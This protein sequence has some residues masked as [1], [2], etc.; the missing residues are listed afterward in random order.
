MPFKGLFKVFKRL[1]GVGT[2]RTPIKLKDLGKV[3]KSMQS[4]IQM[5]G[6]ERYLRT[7]S[8]PVDVVPIVP[9]V[10]NVTDHCVNFVVYVQLQ[11]T[12][13]CTNIVRMLHEIA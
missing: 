6:N 1:K 9:V 8:G 5:A 2:D 4:S 3:R 7:V 12:P 11:M 10:V 13:A